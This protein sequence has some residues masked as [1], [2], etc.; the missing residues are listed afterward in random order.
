[1]DRLSAKL[2]DSVSAASG[3][4]IG[5]AKPSGGGTLTRNPGCPGCGY[6]GWLPIHRRS[7]QRRAWPLRRGSP[8]LS[9]DAIRLTPPK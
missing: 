3:C 6:V 9:G 2:A 7:R 4:G 8:Q 1:M 5:Y